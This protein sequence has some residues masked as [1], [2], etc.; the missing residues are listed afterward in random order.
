[1]GKSGIT[2]NIRRVWLTAAE[3]RISPPRLGDEPESEGLLDTTLIHWGS[4]NRRLPVT[5]TMARRK[6][7]VITAA[8]VSAHGW[9]AR[10]SREWPGATDEF[11]HKAVESRQPNDYHAALLHL[12]GFD[13][14]GWPFTTITAA[15]DGGKPC[16][17]IHEI[18]A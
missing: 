14:S 7:D 4:R 17:V 16:R 8:R 9:L 10:H 6:M 15:F 12:F 13:H 2:K 18:M 1:M 5:K 3:K 11:G